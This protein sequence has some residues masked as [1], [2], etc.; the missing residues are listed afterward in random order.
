M[1]SSGLAK[2]NNAGVF[3]T[4]ADSLAR[5]ILAHKEEDANR[6]YLSRFV[7]GLSET[8]HGKNKSLERLDALKTSLM[9]AK[10]SGDSKTAEQ[11]QKQVSEAV[12]NDIEARKSAEAWSSHTSGFLKAAGLFYPG[13]AG[14]AVAA[15]TNAADSAR[16]E[17]NLSR[18]AI[19]AA[20]GGTK[21]LALKFGFDKIGQSE[22]NL[23]FKAA[24][25]SISNRLA[26]TGLN[27]H[28]YFDS[29]SGEIDIKG[30]VWKTAKSVLNPEQIA[31]DMVV[32]GGGYLAIRKLG[33]T[34]E[35]ARANP[36]M[37]QAITG[38]GFGFSGGF[39]A[40]LELQKRLGEG[41]DLASAVKSGLLQASLDGAAA[42]IGGARMQQLQNRAAAENQT[43]EIAALG[44]ENKSS[45]AD[46]AK[47]V[48]GIYGLDQR[49]I[50]RPRIPTIEESTLIDL[51][52]NPSKAAG[53]ELSKIAVPAPEAGQVKISAG[54]S[55]AGIR[56][57]QS[58]Q[59][60]SS[61]MRDLQAQGKDAQAMLRVQEVLSDKS[62]SARL[63]PEKNLLI[64]HI[65]PGSKISSERASLADLLACCNPK[66]LESLLAKDLA[67]KHIFPDAGNSPVLLQVPGS[68]RLRF[69][70]PEALKNSDFALE[71]AMKL[72]QKELPNMN[73]ASPGDALSAR[74]KTVSE[75]LRSLDM[76]HR[77]S[78][79]HDVRLIADA[80]EHLKMPIDRY[81]GGGN[82]T[83]AFK[84]KDGQILRVTDKPFRTDWGER[85]L[86]L[87]N[88]REVQFDASILG[89]KKQVSLDGETVT[90]YFQHQ[91]VTPVSLKDLNYFNRL[92]DQNGKYVF[93]DNDMSSWGQSQ[94]AY[95]PLL[96]LRDG[97]LSA[98]PIASRAELSKRGLALIDYDAVRIIGTEPKQQSGRNSWRY[99]N[100]DFEP[101]DR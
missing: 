63:G 48:D 3:S 90:Y 69:S 31:S 84:M 86:R 10:I 19:D 101:F 21:G 6:S 20:I 29:K 14:Y 81:L 50:A 9:L 88:G 72:G 98:I 83:I 42:A 67:G 41:F 80:L 96:K 22:M 32:F 99:G 37:A 70:L 54:G 35:F 17:D 51:N 68:N 30:A 66:L 95:V 91:G 34:P 79:L 26:E 7:I 23:A 71:P 73:A 59:D 57:F 85:T 25:L 36:M 78:D 27:T 46:L 13:K 52:T 4:E 62:G 33:L 58:K 11:A 44:V 74:G 60:L 56:E 38:A 94:L 24:S 77:M 53:Q 55:R 76:K 49:P 8:F 28:T 100:Y 93:W 97:K 5:E 89:Q 61:L 1:E 75:W 47:H 64:Q 16:P 18:Q 43:R 40:N 15:F 12:S 87:D 2:T 39:Y 45:F 82:D 65:E 92:I